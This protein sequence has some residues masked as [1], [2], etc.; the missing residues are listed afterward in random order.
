MS[1]YL[2]ILYRFSPVG[3]HSSVDVQL[4]LVVKEVKEGDMLAATQ[5]LLLLPEE[6]VGGDGGVELE[7]RVPGGQLHHIEPLLP[8]V[9]TTP[10]QLVCFILPT[11]H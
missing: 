4:V 8:A 11:E 7:V 1:T 5:A 10:E 2:V 3:S 9:P 6:E